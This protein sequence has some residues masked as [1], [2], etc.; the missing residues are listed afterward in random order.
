MQR[1]RQTFI[2]ATLAV[3]SFPVEGQQASVSIEQEI[4]AA[5]A[6]RID[7]AQNAVGIVVG[8]SSP[9]G[10]RYLYD[11]MADRERNMEPGPNTVFKIGGITSVFWSLLLADMAEQGELRLDDP[12][13]DYLPQSVDVPT[14]NGQ[15]ITLADLATGTSGLPLR[16]P[17]YVGPPFLLRVQDLYDGL[18]GYVLTRPPGERFEGSF[19]A[20]ALLADTLS[21]SAGVDYV[22]L[23][24]TRIF[25]KLG[26]SSTTYELS[27]EQASRAAETYNP[28]LDVI[29][30][31]GLGAIDMG[32]GI[33]TTAEDLLTFAEAFMRMSDNPLWPATRRM[34]SVV[35]PISGD[36]VA[37]STRLGWL[38]INGEVYFRSASVAGYTASLAIRPE[39]Q[40]AVVVL[41][42]TIMDLDSITSISLHGVLPEHPIVMH[43]PKQA[44]VQVAISDEILDEFVG[45]YRP[46]GGTGLPP[47]YGA[48]VR[49]EGDHLAATVGPT[50]RETDL[51]ALSETEFFAIGDQ[52]TRFSFN[53]SESGVV[54]GLTILRQVGEPFL[55]ERVDEER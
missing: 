26:M 1:I 40:R 31:R 11:G 37:S 24:R 36:D 10:K 42:N 53:R 41:A 21:R 39:Q 44:L 38:D 47:G 52:G 17:G 32:S 23:L 15:Q 28:A 29:P 46:M 14:F 13:S 5:L 18:S 48:T 2:V 35:R 55:L 30:A 19:L 51:G 6:N 45:E 12:I 27:E 16:V 49:R 4:E 50:R 33:Y 22:D 43:S 34:L 7:E 8:I 25:N 3:I 54:T 20:G 9:E